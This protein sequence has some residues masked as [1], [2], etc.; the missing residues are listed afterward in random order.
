MHC[1]AVEKFRDR[2]KAVVIAGCRVSG[3]VANW[4]STV[5]SAYYFIE[6]ENH[7]PVGVQLEVVCDISTYCQCLT[8]GRNFSQGGPRPQMPPLG[9]GPDLDPDEPIGR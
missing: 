3:V 9:Y 7:K 2:V 6:L 4:G 1:S 8:G 5:H